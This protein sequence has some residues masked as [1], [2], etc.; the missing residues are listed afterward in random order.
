MTL[1]NHT[2]ID[3]AYDLINTNI[4]KTPFVSNDYI[5]QITGG[6]ILF[7]LENLQIT[8]SFKFR[9]ASHKILKLTESAKKNGIVAYSSGN[10]GQAVA[11]ASQLNDI[12]AKIVMPTTAPKIK[13]NNT[14]NMVQI[15]F[16]MI[17]KRS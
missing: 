10:H 7:K 12:N 9:G 5:N 11:Y 4:I 3:Q 1:F 16:C 8:G 6:N 14:K 2:N 17:Q 13:I 15:L